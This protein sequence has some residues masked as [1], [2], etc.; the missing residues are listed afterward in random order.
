MTAGRIHSIQTFG[1][2]DGPGIRYVLFLQGCRLRCKFC[3]NRDLWDDGNDSQLM[4]VEEII[5]DI[6]KYKSYYEA[7]GGGVT[8]TGGE[9]LLQMPFVT[10]LFKRCKEEGLHTV[11]DTAAAVI[12]CDEQ[13]DDLIEVTDLFLLD[14]KHMDK[15]KHR[16]LTGAGN[17]KVLKVAK[18]LS[19]KDASTWIRH[20]VVPGYTFDE[21]SAHAVAKF[22][23]EL[24]NVEK[25]ELLPFHQMGAHKWQA[26]D[27]DYELEDVK[28]LT[29]ED[30]LPIRTIFEDYKLP[31]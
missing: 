16:E 11:V 5:E 10:E 14:I 7:S 31:V 20:V 1:T 17:R 4:D 3:H 8:V 12:K 29:S 9:P 18:Y 26:L 6:L 27:E 21:E 15:A 22:V 23:S 25:V 24:T 13:L 28:G 2:V 19:S 30:I